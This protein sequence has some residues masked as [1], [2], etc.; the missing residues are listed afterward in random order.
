MG[1]GW[2]VSGGAS[3]E[4]SGPHWPRHSPEA[5]FLCI[6]HSIRYVVIPW[7][8]Y[9]GCWHTHGT[10]SALQGSGKARHI[11][12]VSARPRCS[13]LLAHLPTPLVRS[14]HERLKRLKLRTLKREHSGEWDNGRHLSCTGFN[15]G[16][17]AINALRRKS[18]LG[19]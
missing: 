19:E 6:A 4:P 3:C 17:P 5:T 2:A 10:G 11:G 16:K 15:G 1:G 8:L 9:R 18:L 13:Q 7:I 12:H 14:L